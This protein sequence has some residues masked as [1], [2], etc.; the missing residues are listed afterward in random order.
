[1]FY[2]GIQS[3]PDQSERHRERRYPNDKISKG[4]NA[5]KIISGVV[6]NLDDYSK[7]YIIWNPLAIQKS[8]SKDSLSNL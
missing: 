4:Y 2:Y 5:N 3:P 8:K 7:V 6:N 1:M